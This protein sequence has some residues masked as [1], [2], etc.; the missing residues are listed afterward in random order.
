MNGAATPLVYKKTGGSF[1]WQ[2]GLS[3]WN[4][5]VGAEIVLEVGGFVDFFGWDLELVLDEGFEGGP[6]VGGG[7]GAHVA[8]GAGADA[9]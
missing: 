8:E 9:A 1:R 6:D 2:S 4:G 3:W 7:P 5:L